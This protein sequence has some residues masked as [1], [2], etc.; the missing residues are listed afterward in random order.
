[1]RFRAAAATYLHH[2]HSDLPSSTL[3]VTIVYKANI[4]TIVSRCCRSSSRGGGVPLLGLDLP[5]VLDFC[6]D[7]GGI[8]ENKNFS[9]VTLVSEYLWAL[10]T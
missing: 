4:L 5:P 3:V 1:M 8:R 10:L 7:L 9:E 2:S 6:P